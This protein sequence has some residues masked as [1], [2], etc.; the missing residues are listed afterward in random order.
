MVDALAQAG[1]DVLI[2]SRDAGA[3]ER[4]AGEVACATGRETLG[5]AC[6]VG[7]WSE[8]DTLVDTAY[9]RFGRVDIL[10]N[11][12]GISPTYSSLDTVTEALFDKTIAVNLRGPFR[13]GAL[14]GTRMSAGDG[15]S[16]INIS[17]TA[18]IHPRG[19]YVPYAAAKAGLNAMTVGMAHAFGPAVRV[20]AV[21]AGPFQT[22]I[23][24]T[25]DMKQFER[26]ARAF[27]LRRIGQ[28]HEIVGAVLYF[29]GDMSTYTTGSILTVNGGEP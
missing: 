26:H 5:H 19:E 10:V 27:A 18:V 8:I 23:T 28:P 22:D 25:W 12:A 16:I 21:M 17:S 15:G 29:A 6:H 3:C 9:E 20:N 7:R 14:V 24:A 2:A 11:N 13:L 1:A 4:V